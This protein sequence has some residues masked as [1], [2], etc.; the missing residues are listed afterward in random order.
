MLP[1]HKE[2]GKGLRHIHQPVISIGP[3]PLPKPTIPITNPMSKTEVKTA[4]QIPHFGFPE[5]TKV[6][7]PASG[8]CFQ[9]IGNFI[10][11]KMSPAVNFEFKENLI[12]PLLTFLTDTWGEANA[13]Y[14]TSFDNPG[15]KCVPQK[16][17]RFVNQLHWYLPLLIV[18]TVYYFSLSWMEAEF[19][20]LQPFSN[21]I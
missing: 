18:V 12:N 21:C 16:I 2:T 11:R 4:E 17:K 7:N 3:W 14:P 15:L 10:Y 20:F 19:A 1:M 5:L 9:E 13:E 8:L 6:I